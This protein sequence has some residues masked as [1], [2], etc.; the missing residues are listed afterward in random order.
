[1][2]Q[3]L[4]LHTNYGDL[5]IE[6]FCELIPKNTKVYLRQ[7]FLALCASGYYDNTKFHRNVKGVFIQGGDPTGKGKGGESI[8]GEPIEDEFNPN[9]KVI[10]GITVDA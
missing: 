6:L 8:T 10:D 4:T 2:K 1:M 3:S 7:N 5:K 9:I